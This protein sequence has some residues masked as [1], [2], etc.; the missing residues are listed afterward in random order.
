MVKTVAKHI[1]STVMVQT[2]AKHILS[3]VMVQTV[4]KHILSTVMVQTV[5][6][7]ILST[8]MVQTHISDVHRKCRNIVSYSVRKLTKTIAL[9]V[10]LKSIQ[11]T[12]M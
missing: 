2:V 6:K 4:A 7:H 3:T 8:V 10:S 1:L 12:L 9:L 5:A 11:L